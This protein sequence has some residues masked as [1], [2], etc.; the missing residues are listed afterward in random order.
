MLQAF[1]AQVEIDPETH[2]ATIV[3]PAT[4]QG[5]KVIV[6][7]DISSA[8]FWL[9]AA[10]IVPDS[11]LVIENIGIN[12][13]RTGILEVLEMMGANI[14]LENQ[15]IVTGEPVADLRVRSSQLKAC[16]IE[17]DVIPRLI[18]EIP[19]LAVAAIFAQGTTVIRD[20]AELRVKESDRLAVIASQLNRMGAKIT[21]LPDGLEITGGTPL[22]GTD[23]DS[24]SDHRIAMSLAIAALN[25]K[26]TTTIHRAEAAAISYPDFVSTLKKV[27][28][29]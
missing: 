3:G 18:D 24:Y 26:G 29:E 28:G 27:V 1:G 11:E 13:T 23:V 2:S 5:Q 8:A 17:G 22:I 25:A 12:P 9:V 6:P 10:C 19:I 15:R 21:E 16:T 14:Q 20:A 4:L 7:G